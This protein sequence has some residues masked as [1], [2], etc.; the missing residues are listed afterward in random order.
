MKKY[1]HILADKWLDFT[2]DL[3]ELHC[4]EYWKANPFHIQEMKSKNLALN[5]TTKGLF[6]SITIYFCDM[7]DNLIYKYNLTY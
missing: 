7:I 5:Y 4:V 1:I 6:L 2:G 3:E